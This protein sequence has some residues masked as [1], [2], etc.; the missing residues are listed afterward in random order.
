MN[1]YRNKLKLFGSI[2]FVYVMLFEFILPMNKVLPKPT[3]LF[4]SLLHVWQDYGLLAGIMI[5]AGAVY[6]AI[7]LSILLL[8]LF[9]GAI[10]KLL[11][12]QKII[13]EL[14]QLFKTIPV[15]ILIVLTAFW[16]DG[17]EL[18]KVIFIFVVTMISLTRVL[19]KEIFQTKSEYLDVAKNL[20]SSKLYSEVFWNSSL[21]GLL[22]LTERFQRILWLIVL[23]YEFVSVSFGIGTILRLALLYKDFGAIIVIAIILSLLI[24][25]GTL[26]IKF[27]KKKIAFW[28]S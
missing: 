12:E 9:R 20:N 15:F 6:F 16:F 22:N 7:G 2:V 5:T 8:W 13:F 11:L 10:I 27:I 4:E 23:S 17:S 14:L 18:A 21:P 1:S 26:V 24:W 28:E 3:I 19:A 25:C